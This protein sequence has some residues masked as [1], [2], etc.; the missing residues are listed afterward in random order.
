MALQTQPNG[1][2]IVPLAGSPKVDGTHINT[3]SQTENT[4][5]QNGGNVDVSTVSV[6]SS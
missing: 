1:S 5:V 6:I 4:L 3:T 2:S